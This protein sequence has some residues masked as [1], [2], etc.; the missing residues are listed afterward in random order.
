MAENLKVTLPG[1]Y[2]LALE[3]VDAAGVPDITQNAGEN[4]L[5]AEA[6]A[7]KPVTQEGAEYDAAA[8]AD[9]GKEIENVQLVASQ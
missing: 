3:N 7:Q 2:T 4:A 5:Q 9:K 8:E 6:E 1:G